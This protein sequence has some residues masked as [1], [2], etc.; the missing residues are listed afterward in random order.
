MK[1]YSI[2]FPKLVISVLFLEEGIRKLNEEGLK[3]NHQQV[4]G[5]IKLLA[6]FTILAIF[7]LQDYKTMLKKYNY[8]AILETHSCLLTMTK[9][10]M[11]MTTYGDQLNLQ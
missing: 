3:S 8:Q 9:S 6:S 4:E 7:H 5:Y 2:L 10:K 11:V 1:L